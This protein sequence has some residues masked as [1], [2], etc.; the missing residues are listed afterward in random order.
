[1]LSGGDYSNGLEGVGMVAA[2]ELIAEFPP[3][4]V[5]EDDDS[6]VRTNITCVILIIILHF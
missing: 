5:S 3:S 4:L 6:D 1:M 2:T